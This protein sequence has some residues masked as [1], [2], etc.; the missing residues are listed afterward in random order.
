ML[1]YEGELVV[2][3]RKDAKNVW[4]PAIVTTAAIPY[5]QA[6]R[7]ITR[8]NGEKRQETFRDDMIWSVRQIIVHLTRGTTLLTGTLVMTGTTSGVGPF[9]EL[10]G[11][12]KHN[13]NVEIELA[14]FGAMRNRIVFD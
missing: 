12:V 11:F 1:D 2:I 5:P 14:G 4:G 10:K 3:I 8:V 9:L 7:Y 13:D 6:L